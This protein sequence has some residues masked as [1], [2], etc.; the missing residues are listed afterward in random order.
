MSLLGEILVVDDDRLVRSAFKAL[1]EAEGYSVLLAKD[2]DEAVKVFKEHRPL[3]VLMDV[4]MPKKNGIAACSEIRVIDP[5]VPILSFTAMPNDV[6]MLRT[7][8]SGA[9]DYIAKDRP[10]EEFVARVNAAI[11]KA[12]KVKSLIPNGHDVF[13]AGSMSV[14]FAT[15]KLTS[16][17]GTHDLTKSE[18]AFLKL[19]ISSRGRCFSFAEIFAA[20]RGDGYVGDDAAIRNMVSRLKHKLGG[21]GKR[22]VNLRSCGYKFAD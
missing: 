7:L 13:K 15:M 19:L 4:M 17:S 8:G 16:D 20:L 22:I 10:P 6:A 1:F 11:R 21:E 12:E 14:D 3:L 18:K 2:G 5:L 9:D